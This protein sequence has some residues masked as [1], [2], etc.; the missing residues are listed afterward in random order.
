MASLKELRSRLRSVKNT[1]KI[2]SAMKLVSA[3]KLRRAQESVVK[4]R[5]YTTALNELL[6]ELVT[7]L[8]GSDVS[9]ALMSTHA[10]VKK[11]KILVVGGNRGLCGGYNS[12]INKGLESF[13]A[14]QKKLHPNVVFESV[15]FGRKVAEYYRRVKRDFSESFEKL[16]EEANQWPIED[17]CRGFEQQFIAGEVDEVWVIYTR[18]KS[19]L[20]MTVTSEKLLPMDAS[21][22]TKAAESTSGASSVTL[23]EPSVQDVF[24]AVIPRILRSR[25]RQ[26]AL[27]SK[28]SEH[29][30][31]MTA[32]DS[33]T[34]NAGELSHKLKLKENKQRQLGITSQL[35]DIVGGAEALK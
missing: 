10:E 15:L 1:K 20:S 21:L 32:M 13:I 26:A 27:E 9:H 35:L 31:R 22:A 17:V 16:S 2:T 28:A 18:F 24:S 19:A 11:I 33:A 23:F 4:S 29:G 12:N 30:S 5:Q 14:Q 3:A 25:V 8:G 34:K 6:G 7:E